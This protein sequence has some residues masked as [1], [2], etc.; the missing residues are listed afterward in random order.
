MEL[1]AGQTIDEKN[2]IIK[3][4]KE[5]EQLYRLNV[6]IDY[7]EELNDYISSDRG[8]AM[9]QFRLKQ[10]EYFGKVINFESI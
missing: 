3:L 2:I 10:T 5:G 6:A 1:L 7:E 8:Q 9:K 4:A